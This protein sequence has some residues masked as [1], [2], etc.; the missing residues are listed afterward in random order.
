MNMPEA[1]MVIEGL[2]SGVPYRE[3]AKTVAFGR[4]RYI[5]VVEHLLEGAAQGRHGK[6]RYY[7]VRANYG[8]GKTHFLHSLWGRAEDRNFVVT[9]AAISRETPL[10]RLD[11]LYPK[12]MENTF[13]PGS[14]LAGL[15]AIVG[16][17]FAEPGILA[18]T[19]MLELSPRVMTVVEN[20]V[21]QNE[22]YEELL[23]DLSGSF[24]S[25]SDLKRV[26]RL[27]YGKPLKLERS[28]LRDEG[29]QYVRLL[30]YLIH[31]AGYAGW[32]ILFDEVELIGKLGKGQRSRAYAN[33]GQFLTANLEHTVT[34][35]ALAANFHAD[36]L[37]ARQDREVAPLWLQSRPK[38]AELAPLCV[39]G[40][41][42]LMEAKR[43]NPLS[44][45]DIRE[46]IAQMYLLHQEAYAWHAPFSAAELYEKVWKFSPLRDTKLRTWVRL[47]LTV[48][49]VWF[50][51]NCDPVI[52]QVDALLEANLE[53]DDLGATMT[54]P[55]LIVR[56]P[57][58]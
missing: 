14:S 22:G 50:Q 17:A 5:E 13:V 36:V 20:I 21:A 7:L 27:N 47:T 32:L 45:A 15:D 37:N 16:R 54:E 49:D 46:L 43:L 9:M 25:L 12:L 55:P 48:L 10:D 41:D 18:E 56:S 39:Q 29:M 38:E 19:R 31:K 8:E 42:A 40:I 52:S 11:Y 58:F 4:G 51:Y 34:V 1:R 53:E 2:R 30:D 57:L 26:H 35:W 33:I 6:E 3:L 28:S 24:L 44:E 23:A